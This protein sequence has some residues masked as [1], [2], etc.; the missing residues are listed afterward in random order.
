M[1]IIT[2]FPTLG[3]NSTYPNMTTTRQAKM[4]PNGELLYDSGSSGY[5]NWL[6]KYDGIL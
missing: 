5:K 6:S 2:D 4:I 1:I 3:E